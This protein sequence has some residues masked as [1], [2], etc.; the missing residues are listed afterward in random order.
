[1][2][3]VHLGEHPSG[4]WSAPVSLVE[5]NC[6]L[7]FAER[8][9]ESTHTH[10]ES[11]L[12]GFSLRRVS[13]PFWSMTTSIASSSRSL[14]LSRTSWSI[15]TKATQRK[16]TA[17]HHLGWPPGTGGISGGRIWTRYSAP[18]GTGGSTISPLR[19]VYVSHLQASGRSFE[20]AISA[21]DARKT[22]MTNQCLD[23]KESTSSFLCSRPK[24]HPTPSTSMQG[25]RR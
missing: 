23:H 4:S 22:D 8:R 12:P 21:P 18:T 20:S 5:Q 2:D 9:E 3:G 11:G 15:Q 16:D 1:M 25:G 19:W 14:R 24:P 7:D 13:T 10:V 6:L 17:L